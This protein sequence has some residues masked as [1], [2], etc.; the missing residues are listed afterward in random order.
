MIHT[1]LM[2]TQSLNISYHSISFNIEQLRQELLQFYKKVQFLLSI[3]SKGPPE[4]EAL[5]NFID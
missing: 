4:R 5:C 2:S 3:N 1:F